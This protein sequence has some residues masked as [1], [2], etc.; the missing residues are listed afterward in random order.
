MKWFGV[1][2]RCLANGRVALDLAV[3]GNVGRG[4]VGTLR[5]KAYNQNHGPRGLSTG[6]DFDRRRIDQISAGDRELWAN[7][8]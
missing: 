1:G 7:G 6:D 3:A 4:G 2:F 5:A 8:L